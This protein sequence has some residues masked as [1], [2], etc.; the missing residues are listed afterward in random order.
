M[1]DK[2]FAE[3]LK[4][5]GKGKDVFEQMNEVLLDV[6]TP[7]NQKCRI[8]S[9]IR[10]RKDL[11]FVLSLIEVVDYLNKNQYDFHRENWQRGFLSQ[12]F[13]FFAEIKDDRTLDI[14]LQSIDAEELEPIKAI[15]TLAKIG[16]DKALAAL[17][18]RLGRG[19]VWWDEWGYGKE[20][21]QKAL[22]SFGNRANEALLAIL[23]NP[24]NKYLLRMIAAKYLIDLKAVPFA[25]K[26]MFTVLMSLF[27]DKSL[28]I[29]QRRDAAG[30]LCCIEEPQVA[31]IFLA[32]LDYPEYEAILCDWQFIGHFHGL[33]DR[34]FFEPLMQKL[35]EGKVFREEVAPPNVALTTD[36]IDAFLVY[37]NVDELLAMLND[38]N[39]SIQQAAIL[40]VGRRQLQEA[41]EPLESLKPKVD[42]Y[43]KGSITSSLY[44]IRNTKA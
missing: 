39:R 14:L 37:T 16:T 31:D 35:E 23:E 43:L 32:Y 3:L 9:G 22:A 1:D 26:R 4:A 25:S 11:R 6:N 7:P 44:Q 34:R 30:I 8:V 2:R 36:R 17:I 42:F 5:Y 21:L 10:K 19:F 33:R 29:H 13:W 15:E 18:S 40:E 28:S 38:T 12:T 27:E 41:I 20:A 24:E